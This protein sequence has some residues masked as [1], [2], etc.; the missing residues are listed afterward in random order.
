HGHYIVA[1]PERYTA[2]QRCTYKIG[3]QEA[4]ER[5]AV[6]QYRYYL[7]LISHLGCEEDRGDEDEELEQ[8]C[9]DMRNEV[10]EI[11]QYR[12]NGRFPFHEVIDLFGKIYHARYRRHQQD[13]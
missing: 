4:L 1:G 3:P 2:H 6:S 10:L 11:V 7:R 8:E 12:H 9:G 5:N 13:G